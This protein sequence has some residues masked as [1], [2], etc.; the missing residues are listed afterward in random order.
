MATFAAAVALLSLQ[1]SLIAAKV[2]VQ[3]P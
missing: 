1:R 2:I 3:S